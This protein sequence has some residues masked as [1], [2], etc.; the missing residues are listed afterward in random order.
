MIQLTLTP[1]FGGDTFD[2]NIISMTKIIPQIVRHFDLV[3]EPGVSRNNFWAVG[4]QNFV[5]KVKPH[6]LTVKP[7][8]HD[9]STRDRRDNHRQQ[10]GQGQRQGHGQGWGYGGRPNTSR[11]NQWNRDT[12]RPQEARQ[13]PA[14]RRKPGVSSEIVHPT[15]AAERRSAWNSLPTQLHTNEAAAAAKHREQKPIVPQEKSLGPHEEIFKQTA[16][17][18][19]DATTQYVAKVTHIVHPAEENYRKDSAEVATD[20][21]R[22]VV[23]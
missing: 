23:E 5:C 13:S 22:S 19:H 21:S 8:H 10:Q 1:Q 16:N 3:L 4:F 18:G 14:E 9:C 6:K 17:D 12:R 7:Q 2:L 15:D 20:V 11:S